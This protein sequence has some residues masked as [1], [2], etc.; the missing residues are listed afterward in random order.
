MIQLFCI[1]TPES[2]LSVRQTGVLRIQASEFS[3]Q[4]SQVFGNSLSSFGSRRVHRHVALLRGMSGSARS[5][6]LI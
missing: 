3:R 6:W 5:T 1:T 4:L 2:S